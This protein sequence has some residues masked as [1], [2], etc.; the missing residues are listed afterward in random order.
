M[1]FTPP[2]RFYSGP[3]TGIEACYGYPYSADLHCASCGSTQ[4]SK[5]SYRNGVETFRCNR[6]KRVT[7][8]SP[9]EVSGPD[10]RYDVLKNGHVEMESLARKELDDALTDVLYDLDDRYISGKA[11]E[12]YGEYYDDLSDDDRVNDPSYQDERNSLEGDLLFVN[13][14][15]ALKD[16][17]IDGLEVGEEYNLPDFPVSVVRVADASSASSN[18]RTA[19]ARRQTASKPKTSSRSVKSKAKPKAP[20]KKTP[21][22]KKAPAKK[23]TSRRY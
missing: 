3:I 4:I 2:S 7:V 15:M 20:A 9:Y 19:P 14:L 16:G 22:K 23:A 8:L 18:R 21:A 10:A 1:T 5:P 12:Y 11:S 17:Y 13:K 6:C